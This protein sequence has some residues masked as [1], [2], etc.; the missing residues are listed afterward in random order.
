MN[1]A[2]EIEDRL[3]RWMGPLLFIVSVALYLATLCPG[4]FLGESA[5]LLAAH[6]GVD[7]FPAMAHPVW[8]FFVHIVL[9][10][11]VGGL[12]FKV[13]I[14]SALFGGGCVW[15][16]YSLIARIAHDRTNE[17]IGSHFVP[18]T[19]QMISGVFAALFLAISTPFWVVATRAFPT[20]LDIFLFML[21]VRLLFA[22]G[23]R[24][25]AVY[26]YLFA[27]VCGVGAVEYATFIVWL[28]V[29]AIV[30]LVL[31]WMVGLL[32]FRILFIA[33]LCFLL[34]LSLYLVEAWRYCLSPAYEW[35]D[36]QNFFQVIWYIWRDQYRLIT[37]SLPQVG[38]LMVFLVSVLPFMMVLAFPR[39]MRMGSV[40]PGSY[41]LRAILFILGILALFNLPIAPWPLLGFRPLLVMPYVLMGAWFGYMAGYWFICMGPRHRLE[42]PF[43]FWAKKV[44]RALLLP[45][46]VLGM[47]AAA[48]INFPLANGR[49]SDLV[50]DFCRKVID[51]LEGRTWLLSNGELDELF[52]IEAAER[53]IPLEVLCPIRARSL[54]YRRYMAGLFDNPRLKGLANAGLGS[55]LGEWIASTPEAINK[56]AVLNTPDLWFESGCEFVP[57]G[58]LYLGAR[59]AS[60]PS[61]GD[62]AVMTNK[63]LADQQLW[64][65]MADELRASAASKPIISSWC[66]GTLGHL[67]K[68]AN[69]TGFYLEDR[70]Q[71]AM[72][73]EAYVQSIS[74]NSN[75]LSAFLNAISMAKKEKRPEASS[76]QAQFEQLV[77]KPKAPLN[78][79]ALAYFYG[80]VHSPEAFASRGAAWAMSGKPHRAMAD[81]QRAL[82]MGANSNNMQMV[83][84]SLYSRQD[85]RAESEVIYEQML[86][87]N[88]NFRP[89]LLGLARLAVQ[90]GKP[91]KA[92]EYIRRIKEAGGQ[93]DVVLSL[94]EAAVEIADARLVE[95]RRILQD[96]LKTEPENYQAWGLLALIAL[97]EQDERLLNQCVDKLTVGAEKGGPLNLFL[98]T[99]A[100]DR[101]ELDNARQ[102]LDILLKV[103]PNNAQAL[104]MLL[105]LD[106][107]E[108]KRD[109]A[110]RHVE[111]LLNVD[112]QNA[113]ANYVLASLQIYRGE[114][115]MAEASLRI[116][117]QRERTTQVLNDYAW[118]LMKQ[119]RYEEALAAAKE[120]IALNEHNGAAWDTLGNILLGLNQTDEA[121][122]ALQRALELIPHTPEVILHMAQVY[123]KK[124]LYEEALKL[125]SDLMIRPAEMS[126]EVSDEVQYLISRLR[127]RIKKAA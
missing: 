103:Q 56:L 81:M 71:N 89:A 64:R 31:A 4:A 2:F 96:V 61:P 23:Y 50:N 52:M 48:T 92:R 107:R 110:E 53:N 32:T 101:G 28:P 38:W 7:P 51:R 91:D 17:E 75:N 20:T 34:G 63:F 70:G 21:A 124:G 5:K 118:V 66:L 29:L 72:A 36:F 114:Y 11:P 112:P 113:M 104:E 12:A 6:A 65:E 57:S 19:V 41:F 80:Y 78:S 62:E 122:K 111:N 58:M 69:D 25:K 97:Q 59:K 24:Q 18:A 43:I 109:Q 27:L 42:A 1:G 35:R 100:M 82:T 13:N 39:P 46:L 99:V 8:G 47:I 125:V 115:E 105:R 102:L 33:T 84:A 106:M 68:L 67:S 74:L 55:V 16:M 73:F 95:A 60:I 14:V 116:S 54:A 87:G 88:P 98:A 79:W 117:L 22:M 15:L 90:N 37:T 119:K 30:A 3:G 49:S 86:K 120:A 44:G 121:E 26:L 77:K 108:A 9:L 40:S 76:L 126:P 83:M 85:M 94:E 123:E 10:I 127:A 45:V 93:A